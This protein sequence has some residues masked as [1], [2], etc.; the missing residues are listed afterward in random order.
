MM[1]HLGDARVSTN[2]LLSLTPGAP[3][4]R[5]LDDLLWREPAHAVSG[6]LH[7]ISAHLGGD[8]AMWTDVDIAT[9]SVTLVDLAD[10]L[11]P[12]HM[13]ADLKHRPASIAPAS[14]CARVAA[15]GAQLFEPLL[16]DGCD[17]CD[18]FPEP[19]PGHVGT[20]PVH[21]LMAVP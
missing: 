13:L 18:A 20:H 9:G 21:G 14:L 3:T 15:S 1:V 16:A 8:L 7:V 17:I 6:L 12:A 4:A 19:W 2:A 5:S 11:A 10:P